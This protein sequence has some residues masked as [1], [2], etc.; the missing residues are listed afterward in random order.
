MIDAQPR[1]SQLDH[2]DQW[3]QLSITLST[4]SK[5]PRKGHIMDERQPIKALRLQPMRAP[6]AWQRA[7]VLTSAPEA[8]SLI[9]LPNGPHVWS[10]QPS[11][12]NNQ[13]SHCHCFFIP[14]ALLM[15]TVVL[16][17][18]STAITKFNLLVTCPDSQD[19]PVSCQ[20]E[21]WM[22]IYNERFN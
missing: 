1:W 17:P 4:L 7:L 14:S 10:A 6:T 22:I 3:A 13:V 21:A 12:V 8:H 5:K 11:S 19:W 9:C 15:V 20:M 16:C 2:H 18:Q